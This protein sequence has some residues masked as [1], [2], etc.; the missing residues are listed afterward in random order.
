VAA[1]PN[2]QTLMQQL[3][4]MR[5]TR[6]QQMRS[7]GQQS[8]LMGRQV[9]L[10]Q[11]MNAALQNN[12]RQL[13]TL[14]TTM[15]TGFRNLSSSFTRSVA[16]L[17]SAIGRTA[18]GGASA[19]GSAAMGV[20]RMSA[21]AVSGLS[22]AIV[23]SLSTVLP[24]AIAGYLG[25]TMVWDNIEEGTKKELQENF[26][27]VMK[28]IFGGFKDTEFGKSVEPMIDRMEALFSALGDTLDDLGSKLGSLTGNVSKKVEGVKNKVDVKGEAFKRTVEPMEKAGKIV[29]DT[30]SGLDVGGVGLA[31]VAGTAIAAGAAKLG[32]ETYKEGFG[33]TK[34]PTP[35]PIKPGGAAPKLS[36]PAKAAR[37]FISKNKLPGNVLDILAG[38]MDFR[39]MKAGGTFASKYF[40][41]FKKVKLGNTFF[42]LGVCM[43][44]GMAKFV[45]EE[46]NIM[47]MEHDP[48]DFT[49]EE[50]DALHS[51]VTAQAWGSIIGGAVLGTLGAI[52]GGVVGT[53]AGPLAPYIALASGALASYY[54]S[55]AGQGVADKFVSLPE[56]ITKPRTGVAPTT[57]G[58]AVNQRLDSKSEKPQGSVT[59][60]PGTVSSGNAN[61]D[62]VANR[63]KRE[64]VRQNPYK[65]AEGGTPTVGIGHKLTPEEMKAGGVFI[66]G[67][68]VPLDLG[69]VKDPGSSEKGKKQLTKEQVE[70]LYEQDQQKMMGYVRDGIGKEAFDKLSP[71][72]QWALTDLAFAMGP[73]FAKDPKLKK[74]IEAGDTKGVAEFIRS[75]ARYYT[76]DGKKVKSQYHEK[77]A[78]GR[79]D[80][81][82]GGGSMTGG[83]QTM[84]A[85][86][87]G[88]GEGDK[89]SNP[90]AGMSFSDRLA[91]YKSKKEGEKSESGTKPD[92][93]VQ[94]PEE[95]KSAFAGFGSMIS[96]QYSDLKEMLLK[97]VEGDMERKAE[98]QGGGTSIN[99]TGGDTN[100]NSNSGGGGGGGTPTYSA[101]APAASY[102]SQFTSIAGIQRTA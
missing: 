11:S 4:E 96:N 80:L 102:Q 9:Q 70:K 20:G 29:K 30:F 25:K 61:I 71:D 74:M 82:M 51:W 55:K 63:K 99:Y 40:A 94:K 57:P 87:S 68:L 92:D 32:Y 43:E 75:R 38:R 89:G 53:V 59:P 72:Q 28:N 5:A 45:H 66:D 24:V 46:I 78:E 39:I 79:A 12:T 88:G 19:A 34:A 14:N 44:V 73:G 98:D 27:G 33:A 100:V 90:T 35:S 65:S 93:T 6:M 56:S 50:A 47:V 52:G 41:E 91:Y 62:F 42:V 85:S 23:S 22:S 31:D 69:G 37:S 21:S 16:G 67:K 77:A 8:Q 36:E 18:A 7:G 26:A 3:S 76:K 13:G 58:E 15:S 83:G 101:V 95:K 97:G 48:P 84:L 86:E 64:G 17:S 81:Y 10:T 60:S 2:R 1:D 54:G 49:Q